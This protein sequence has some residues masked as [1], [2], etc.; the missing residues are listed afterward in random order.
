MYLH[1][2]LYHF[3]RLEIGKLLIPTFSQIKCDCENVAQI[4]LKIDTLF[5]ALVYKK[6]FFAHYFFNAIYR[7]SIYKTSCIVC[8]FGECKSFSTFFQ[9]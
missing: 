2:F 5:N 8:V 1:L 4:S 3:L 9:P 7:W 6:Y